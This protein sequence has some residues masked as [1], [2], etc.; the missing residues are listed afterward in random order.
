EASMEREAGSPER[1]LRRAEY[2]HLV[3]LGAFENER[4]EL[5]DGLLV[6]MSPIGPPHSSAVQ[7]LTTLLVVAFLGR[8]TVR[9]QLPFA[10]LALSEPEPDVAVVPLGDYAKAH[11]N[12]AHL[13]IEVAE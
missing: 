4:I 2:D 13:I 1:P 8:A 5:L 7:E 11:P 3:S 12:S 10:A 6:P 9:I